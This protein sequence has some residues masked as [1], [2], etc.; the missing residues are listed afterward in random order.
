MSKHLLTAALTLA[1]AAVALACAAAGAD[2][3]TPTS[4]L[5]GVPDFAKRLPEYK[6]GDP[7]FAFNGKDLEG[8]YTYLNGPKYADPDHVFT[9]TA[10][11]MLR[12]SGQGF[13]GITTK[14]AFKDYHLVAEWKWGDKTW[15]VPDPAKPG[16]FLR[17]A[18]A[19]RDAGILV[20]AVGE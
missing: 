1:A 15:D 11:G 2:P 16:Q 4:A 3:S 14:R 6:S 7:A 18:T 10:D 9:V 20:H 12:I 19:A 5:P 17:R 8:W 13:G